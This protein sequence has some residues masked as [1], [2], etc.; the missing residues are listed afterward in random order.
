MIYDTHAVCM[1][2]DKAIFG[3]VGCATMRKSKS[4]VPLR[5][6]NDIIWK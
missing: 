4:R 3:L 2:F 1:M 6:R 5:E